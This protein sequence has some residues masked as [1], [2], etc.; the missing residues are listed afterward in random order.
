MLLFCVTERSRDKMKAVNGM[1]QYMDRAA[2]EK[3]HL[4]YEKDMCLCMR[5]VHDLRLSPKAFS[6][7][8]CMVA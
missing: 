6:F 2:R 4:L 3:M 5:V 1:L 7:T 8:E